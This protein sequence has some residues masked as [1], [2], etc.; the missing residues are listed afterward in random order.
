MQI[1]PGPRHGLCVSSAGRRRRSCSLLAMHLESPRTHRSLK[2]ALVELGQILTGADKV[3][4]LSVLL[5]AGVLFFYQNHR[6]WFSREVVVQIS[7]KQFGPYSLSKPRVLR[8]EGPLGV[9]EVEIDR[10]GA[11]VIAAPCPQKLC[12]RPWVRRPGEVAVCLPNS[13]ILMVKGGGRGAE[14]DGVSR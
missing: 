7:G 2:A 13:F 3:L 12:M 1:L 11:R 4:I 8:F 14:L 6:P 10:Q 5:G 9:S